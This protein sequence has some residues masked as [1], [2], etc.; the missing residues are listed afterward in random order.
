MLFFKRRANYYTRKRSCYSKKIVTG[1][2]N[3]A[4]AKSVDMAT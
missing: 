2:N 1:N 4:V 3:K